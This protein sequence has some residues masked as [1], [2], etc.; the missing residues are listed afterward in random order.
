MWGDDSFR[1]QNEEKKMG[2]RRIEE[3]DFHAKSQRRKEL[4]QED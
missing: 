3:R 1:R 2:E 4:K